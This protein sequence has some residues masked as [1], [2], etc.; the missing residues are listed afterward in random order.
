M[1]NALRNRRNAAVLELEKLIEDAKSFLINYNYYYTDTIHKQRRER[2]KASLA[3]ALELGTQH[4][5]LPNCN[6]NHTSASID[7]DQVVTSISEEADPN[8]ENVSCE[9]ALDCLFAIYKVRLLPQSTPLLFSR[10]LTVLGI[11]KDFCYKYH[12]SS[13]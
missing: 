5:L 3:E 11:T 1:S 10:L 12:H 13:Y 6:S 4:T 7:I 8:M 9:E 2:H